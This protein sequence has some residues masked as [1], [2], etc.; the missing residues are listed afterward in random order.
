MIDLTKILFHL[1]ENKIR[2]LETITGQI[3]DTGKAEIF[4]FEQYVVTFIYY[5]YA[6][7]NYRNYSLKQLIVKI[8]LIV[9]ILF[10]LIG[11]I[12]GIIISAINK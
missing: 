10:V 4:F 8:L 7:K 1:P 12:I 11:V 3:V 9:L 6:Y 2:E 5:P